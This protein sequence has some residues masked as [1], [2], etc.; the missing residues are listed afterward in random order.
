MPIRF[1]GR[2]DSGLSINS[3]QK[4]GTMRREEIK[5][6]EFLALSQ[7]QEYEFNFNATNDPR[8]GVP[9]VARLFWGKDKLE[10]EFFPL[11]RTWGKKLVTVTGKYKVKE[12]EVIEVRTGGSWKNDY[13]D[14]FAIHQGKKVHVADI[15]DSKAK[16]K[17]AQ[18]LRGEISLE[19]LI[20]KK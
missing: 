9:Y 1:E 13:R 10:R 4:G 17:V 18:Y 12:G 2:K 19:Q 7:G 14:W 16:A 3:I 11:E 5:N 6:D 15:G 8:K 20:T